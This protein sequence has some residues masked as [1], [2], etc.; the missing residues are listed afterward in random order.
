M[1]SRTKN[2]QTPEQLDR[3]TRHALGVGLAGTDGDLAPAVEELRNG[4]FNAAYALRL[5]DGRRVVVKIAPPPGADVMTYERGIMATEVAA[6]RLAATNA[7]IPLPAVLAADDS[8]EVCD[9]PYFLM[10]FAEGRTLDQLASGMDPAALAAV[11]R[12]VGAIVRE[13]NGFT[14]PWFGCPGHPGLQAPTWREA[15]TGLIGSVLDDGAA[16]GV[17]Y[18]PSIDELRSVVDHHA[19]VLDHVTVPRL[20]HWDVWDGN[21]VVD[22]DRV[23]AI[24][25]FERALWG[26]PL[27]EVQFRRFRE[28]VTDAMRGY[29]W[30]TFTPHEERRSQLYGL[31]LALVMKTECA[32]RHYDTSYIDD[33]GT[34]M[35]GRAMTWLTT[36]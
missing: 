35:L 19:H 10:S 11:H 16:K 5:A 23:T 25:D 15:F 31:H 36:G 29:G 27:M 3:M 6:M 24:I 7:A 8:G 4:W 28:P 33:I 18:G 17:V 13:I 34:W 9:A 2:H 30:T 26:D 21:V 32:F 22:G 20:V 12:S 14:G 1:D